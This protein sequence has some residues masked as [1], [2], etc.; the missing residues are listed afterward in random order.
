MYQ[1]FETI[2]IENKQVQNLDLHQKR[3][4][5]SLKAL[6]NIKF[7]QLL[8]NTKSIMIKNTNSSIYI[9]ELKDFNDLF[10]NLQLNDKIFKCKIIYSNRID[11]ITI[12]E[13]F[14]RKIEKFRLV[15]DN[16][17]D[18]SHKYLDREQLNF[19]FDQKEEADEIII[20]KKNKILD[21][22]I[23][24]LVFFDGKSWITPAS[25]LLRGTKRELL[26]RNKTMT[27]AEIYEND[28]KSFSRFIQINSMLCADFKKQYH[29]NSILNLQ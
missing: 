6:F 29:I 15:T 25:P 4:E 12:E 24:N 3:M 21:T 22:S 28:L 26:L 13:Y 23:A 11:E 2:K 10:S 9:N 14:P 18:Y 19:L 27:E 1:L 20:V 16:Y 17:I 8:I 7:K 5:V